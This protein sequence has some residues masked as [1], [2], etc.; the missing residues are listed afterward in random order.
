M[1][2]FIERTE[3]EKILTFTGTV[4]NLLTKIKINAEEVLVVKGDEVLT[5][6]DKLINTDSIKLLSVISGG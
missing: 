4:K 6:D 3:K 1:K 2:V 5:E